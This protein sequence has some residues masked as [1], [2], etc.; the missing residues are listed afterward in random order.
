MKSERTSKRRQFIKQAGIATMAS[1]VSA[2]A[3]SSLSSPASDY[4]QK[5]VLFQGDSITDGGRSYDK[6]WN[7]VLGQGYVFLVSSQLWYD[8]INRP[9]MFFNR[10]ISGN[11]V[12]DLLLRWQTDTIALKPDILTILI[13]VN[14][15]YHVIKNIN[16]KSVDEFRSSY[17]ALLQKTKDAL[18]DTKI[19]L[20]EPFI[21]PVGQVKDSQINWQNAIA[22]RQAIVKEMATLFNTVYVPLQEVFLS[23]CK[24]KS[25]DYWVWDG[26]H[27]MPAGH[28]LI[29][30]EWIRMV[31][32]ELKFP[33]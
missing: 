16:P 25:A 10:G 6:D 19:V 22:P 29:A 15:A 8:H 27:P 17:Q 21:L 1:F 23:A 18:P 9:M 32:K 31:K 4:T 20:C 28:Q 11:T 30:H 5:T 7:H 13:G 3:F 14:D 26:I 2:N 12:D 33:A 24:K